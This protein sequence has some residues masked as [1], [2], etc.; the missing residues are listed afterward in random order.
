MMAF[1]IV[2]AAGLPAYAVSGT[3]NGISGNWSDPATWSGGTIA[4]GANFTANFTGVNIIA[5][6][7]I[8][9]DTARTIGNITFTDAT[10]S[11]NDLII[12]GAN[13]LTLDRT[14]AT[15]PTINVTQTGRLLTMGG[16]IAGNDGLL[17]SGAGT[18]VFNAGSNNTFT[19][20]FD[21][22]GGV[23]QYDSSTNANAFGSAANIITFTG[24]ST[25]HNVNNTFTMAQGIAVNPGVTGTLLGAFQEVL[26]VNG[27]VTGS[28]T[29]VVQ[30]ASAG[31]QVNLNNTAN[32]FTGAIRIISV[33]SAVLRVRSLADSA[34]TIGLQSNINNG[35]AFEYASGAIAPLVFNNRQFELITNGNSS[36]NTARQAEIRNNAGGAN[37]MT[38]NTGL[39]V[40]GTGTKYFV[41]SGS[42]SGTNTFAGLIPNGVGGAALTLD[43]QGAGTWI[44]SNANT[45]SGNTNLSAGTLGLANVNA[46]QNSTLDT[47]AS[48]GT[49]QVTFNVAGTNTYN[50]GGLTGLDALA[51]GANT[52]SIGS[53]GTNTTYSSSISGAGGLTKVGAGTLTL[54]AVNSYT[55]ATSIQGGILALGASGSISS[56]SSVLIGVGGEFDTT[57]LSFTM[58]GSQP[59]TWNI[60]PTGA[61]SAGLLD[62][63]ILN[64]TSGNA[65]FNAL[66]PLD[67]AFYIVANYTSLTGTFASSLTPTGYVLD[68]NF[69]NLNQIALVQNAIVPEPA[70]ATLGLLGLAG[71]ML[72]RRRMA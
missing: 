11:S 29:L 21:I 2:G 71:L 49:K 18:L 31:F 23:V 28:G 61:G 72:R 9:L 6:P 16:V 63:S 58:L 33:D 44:L 59:F 57:A 27:A 67:D 52:L 64:I 46:L 51:I 1:A 22:N 5:S 54:A 32:T 41:L 34:N 37:T 15:K 40:T 25:L 53:K 42:N 10:T 7:T 55:G 69:N 12:S 4:D 30:G 68:Y 8:T 20:G 66:A 56:S 36:T 48:S 39:L 38:I 65:T 60:D 62:A 45:F 3:W 26:N 35:G 14:D 17:K 13:I 24:N 43:K 19:G 47:G 70:T 50:I